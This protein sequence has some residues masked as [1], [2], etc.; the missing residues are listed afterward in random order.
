[1]WTTK[2]WIKN[3]VKTRYGYKKHHTTGLVVNIIGIYTTP[4]NMNE[5]ASLEA[6][7]ATADL[8]ENI[9]TYADKGYRSAN[10]EELLKCEN[11]KSSI[12]HKAKKVQ[13]LTIH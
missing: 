12:L 6:V 5:I 3:A 2:P 10:N 7:S 4:A 1:V 8:P 13:S 9:H 11:L